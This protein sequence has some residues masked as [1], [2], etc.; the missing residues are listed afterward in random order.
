MISSERS[1]GCGVS[2]CADA[3][4]TALEV[5]QMVLEKTRELVFN[6]TGASA[7]T[8][9]GRPRPTSEM[10]ARATEC[11]PEVLYWTR[12]FGLEFKYVVRKRLRKDWILRILGTFTLDCEMIRNRIESSESLRTSSLQISIFL[13]QNVREV[14]SNFLK[15]FLEGEAK[16]PALHTSLPSPR[17]GAII[18]APQ[19]P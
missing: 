2:G 11:G 7:K 4:L 5:A 8:G 10:L 1:Q 3:R 12:D 9:S 17:K 16:S 18:L 15:L 13:T 6:P 14:S 19:V